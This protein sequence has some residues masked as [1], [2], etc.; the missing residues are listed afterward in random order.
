MCV[1]ECVCVSLFIYTFFDDG[2]GKWC[3]Q[4]KQWVRFVVNTIMFNINKD[5]NNSR[6]IIISSRY[7]RSKCKR[8]NSSSFS[9]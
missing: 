1:Y 3:D 5:Q 9:N 4:A 8:T 6:T 2:I 7:V